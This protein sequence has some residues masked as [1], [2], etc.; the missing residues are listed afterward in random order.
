M[1]KFKQ[2]SNEN[3]EVNKKKERLNLSKLSNEKSF[4][5]AILFGF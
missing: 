1:K 4:C 2:K 5:Q 3:Q